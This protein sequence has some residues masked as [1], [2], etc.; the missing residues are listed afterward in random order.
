MGLFKDESP[1]LSS[2]AAI[3][4]GLG[5]ETNLGS[6]IVGSW[7]EVFQAPIATAAVTQ[8]IFIAPY[9]CEI[10]AISAVWGVNSTSGNA[11]VQK[12]TGVTAA[13]SGLNAQTAVID[14]SG[15]NNAVHTAALN[16]TTSTLQLASGD[17]LGILFA[18]TMTGL[19]GAV[20][21]I[22]LKRI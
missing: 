18:G 19:V 4:E 9:A 13:G 17:R 12:L 11:I 15:S 7:S 8:N 2:N 6:K 20:I 22:Q 3:D 10:V 16:T 1:L 21:N 14:L 5:V